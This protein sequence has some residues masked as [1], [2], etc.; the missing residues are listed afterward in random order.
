MPDF[1]GVECYSF[2]VLTPRITSWATSHEAGHTYFGGMVPNTYIKSI[3]NEGLT[4]Y[5]DSAGFKNNS[6]RSLDYGYQSRKV[7][8]SLADPFLAHGP[9]GNIGYMRGAYVFKMLENELGMDMMNQCLRRL[10]LDR[11][12]KSTEWSDIE[13]SFST[14]AG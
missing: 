2:T 11:Q 6:D 10:I 4:Q 9:N 8:V 1:Y 5:I 7:K 12:G 14:T 3:W 13:K